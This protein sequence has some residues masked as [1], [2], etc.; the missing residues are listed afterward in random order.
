[1][2]LKLNIIDASESEIRDFVSQLVSQATKSFRTEIQLSGIPWMF[3]KSAN[4]H[5]YFTKGSEA[6]YLENRAKFDDAVLNDAAIATYDDYFVHLVDPK[7]GDAL[8]QAEQL[9]S[10]LISYQTAIK[11]FGVA[12]I[13]KIMQ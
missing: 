13:P 2:N 12:V 11:I 4:N 8:M 5:F 3:M 10:A 7:T 1:M 6:Q 9:E